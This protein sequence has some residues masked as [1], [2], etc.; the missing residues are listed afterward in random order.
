M[1]GSAEWVAAST[2]KL[3]IFSEFWRGA[4]AR[5]KNRKKC[6]KHIGGISAEMAAE[7]SAEIPQIQKLLRK[8]LGTGIMDFTNFYG[9]LIFTSPFVQF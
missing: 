6:L 7:N 3:G 8:L 4:S 2:V 9:T 5:A 1:A